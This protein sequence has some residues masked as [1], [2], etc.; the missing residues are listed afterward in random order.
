MQFNFEI[1]WL[2]CSRDAHVSKEQDNAQI[3]K[4]Y[5]LVDSIGKALTVIRLLVLLLFSIVSC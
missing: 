3:E 2:C 4:L 5:E 1:W